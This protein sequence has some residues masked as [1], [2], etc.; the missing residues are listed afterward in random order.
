MIDE[1][2]WISLLVGG[3]VASISLSLSL[4]SKINKSPDGIIYK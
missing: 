2:E 1:R 4:K 3:K